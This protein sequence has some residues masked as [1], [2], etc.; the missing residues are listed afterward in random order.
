MWE[1]CVPPW[2]ALVGDSLEGIPILRLITS[3]ARKVTS[4]PS[5]VWK[6]MMWEY[7]TSN[8]NAILS[9]TSNTGILLQDSQ[10][11]TSRSRRLLEETII[12]R[13]WGL[14]E[15]VDI[16]VGLP[17]A[18]YTASRPPGQLGI[19]AIPTS[20]SS[21]AKSDP[22]LNHRARRKSF[23]APE[24]V[25]SKTETSAEVPDDPSPHM[26]TYARRLTPPERTL[27]GQDQAHV[28]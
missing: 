25:R 10:T 26:G 8:P 18:I 5:C 15:D 2:R 7:V 17:L 20:P 24:G 16:R 4:R 22:A 28:S 14:I 23:S 3:K 12:G 9:Q 11:Y 19:T 21:P 6:V 13:R 27:S 1:C